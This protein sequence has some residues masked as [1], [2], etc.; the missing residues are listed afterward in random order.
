MAAADING[1]LDEQDA[2]AKRDSEK[3]RKTW[4]ALLA[5]LMLVVLMCCCWAWS[6][7]AAVPNVV[8]MT[9]K[10]ARA[11]LK[12]AGFGADVVQPAEGDAGSEA[13]TS[14]KP[15]T[16]ISQNPRAGRR[17]IK[18]TTVQITINPVQGGGPAGD[19]GNSPI[20]T[21]PDIGTGPG[22]ETDFAGSGDEVVGSSGVIDNRPLIPSAQNMSESA[23]IAT[24]QNAGFNAVVGGY[25]STTAGVTAGNVWYQ[26]PAPGTRANY[27]ATVT[28]WIS[29]GAPAQGTYWDTPYPVPRR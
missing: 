13:A 29:T 25:H 20:T 21:L 10:D 23:G 17:F 27:G 14:A 6:Q 5:L 26:S 22:S 11:T 24:L 15:G 9:E 16:V 2:A 7:M 3:R 4:Y 18:G 12:K 1:N 19:G 28:I 8:G